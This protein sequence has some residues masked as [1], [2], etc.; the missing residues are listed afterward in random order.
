[1]GDH[2][3]RSTENAGLVQELRHIYAAHK[4]RVEVSFCENKEGYRK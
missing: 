2:L 1:M 4:C 3:V